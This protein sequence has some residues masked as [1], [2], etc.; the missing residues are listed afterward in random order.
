MRVSSIVWLLPVLAGLLYGQSEQS[1]GKPI[2]AIQYDPADQPLSARDLKEAQILKIGAALHKTDVSAAID[3]LF[4]TGAYDDI[5]V[6]VQPSGSGVTVRFVTKANFFIGRVAT[7]GRVKSPPNEGQL[8]NATHLSL[9]QPFDPK[10]VPNS[11]SAIKN[12]LMRN[13]LRDATVTSRL[14]PSDHQ[15]MNILFDVHDGSRA[16]FNTP[17][18]TGDPK[19]PEHDIIKATHW[20][21]FLL[22]SWRPVTE[23]LLRDGVERV[24]KKYQSKNRLMANVH[25]KSMDY[26]PKKRTVTP[27]FEI[28]AGPIVKIGVVEAKISKRKLKMY[29]PVYDEGSVDNDLLVEGARNLRDYFQSQGYYQAEV[30]FQVK[31]DQAQDATDIEYSIAKGPLHKLVSVEIAGNKFFRTD[32]LKERMFLRPASFPQFRHG[33][34]SEA[35]R[36]Q[37]EQAIENLYKSNGF[38]DVKVTSKVAEDYKGKTG[39][40][41]IAFTVNEGGQWFVSKLG[42][43]GMATSDAARVQAQLS[44]T[45]GQPFSDYN[46]AA[47]RKTILNYYFSNGYPN[48][49]FEWARSDTDRPNYADV[50]YRITEGAQQFV[51]DVIVTG[52]RTTK[53]R[54]IDANMSIHAG[55]PLSTVGLTNEQ[56]KL[57]DLGIFAKVDAAIQNPDGDLLDKY[58]LYDIEE[59][60]RYTMKFG[61]GAEVAQFGPTA[62][63]LAA[64]VGYSGFSPRLLVDVSRLNFLGIGH[65]VSFQGRLSNLDQR[66]QLSYTVP[67]LPGKQDRNIT[68]TGLYDQARDVL[69]FSSRREEVSTQIS[70]KFSKSVTGMLRFSYRRVS[71]SDVLIP[72]LLVPQ[73][74]QPVRIGMLSANWAQDRR[75][76]PADANRGIYNMVN[77]G[78]ASSVFGSQRSFVKVLARQ[79]TYTP[80]RKGWVLARQLTFGSILPWKVAAGFTGPTYIPLPERFFGG[81]ADSSRAFPYNGAG[82]RDI[83]TPAGPGGTATEATGFPLGGNAVLFHQTELRFP[84]LGDNIGGVLFHD[85]GNVYSSI[86]KISFRAAQRNLQD[87]DYMVHAAGFGIRYRTPVGP[88][89]LD[90]SYSINPPSFNGFK[91]TVQQ[92]LQC[93][94]NPTP[95]RPNADFCT[96]QIQRTSHFQFFFSIGQAF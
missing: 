75:D 63:E 86:D 68:F 5:Q 31:P 18:I 17:L 93:R 57:Y 74:L 34:Y 20:H 78:I 71:T 3:R 23:A 38:Q 60:S 92:L 55:D 53:Q 64:P 15:Q 58:V 44:S 47:D 4:A 62:N 94:P 24:R 10:E 59:A 9:G 72:A 87:F 30:Q 66:G 70:Q 84:L 46:V 11:E 79:A 76:N 48:A 14:D 6:D 2:V 90:L 51:R 56:H 28:A 54:V 43:Q 12:L 73:L 49:K 36:K 91:G 41:A 22:P 37:D 40:L 95:D 81:G 7:Q 27:T 67:R 39:D 89:R 42:V 45:E 50:T 33:R 52:T 85:M 69:T 96:P 65:T 1:E 16:T 32:D 25:L 21:R 83:G 13:G 88:I 61:F 19:L 80:I 26:D 8:V 82:P 35:F 77:A 29:I